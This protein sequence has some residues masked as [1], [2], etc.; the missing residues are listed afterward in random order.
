MYLDA[1]NIFE[2][3]MFGTNTCWEDQQLGGGSEVVNRQSNPLQ[4]GII[5]RRLQLSP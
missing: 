2:G 1:Q 4:P 3:C 5:D